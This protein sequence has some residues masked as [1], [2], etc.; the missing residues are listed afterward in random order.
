MVCHS[1]FDGMASAAK[2]LLGGEE[3][4]PGCDDDARV[5]DSD[6]GADA[7]SDS[8]GDTEDPWGQPYNI[9]CDGDDIT[10]TSPGP[11]KKEGTEDDIV[12]GPAATS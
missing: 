7:D 1:D 2:W 11:D 5:D 9:I 3:P 4:Y 6:L 12:V 8:A 10:V